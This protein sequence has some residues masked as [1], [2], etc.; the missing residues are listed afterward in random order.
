MPS[1]RARAGE[2]RLC[3]WLNA[4]DTYNPAAVGRAVA[5][6]AQRPDIDVLYSGI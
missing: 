5:L 3:A 4:D 1:T 6:L 2:R